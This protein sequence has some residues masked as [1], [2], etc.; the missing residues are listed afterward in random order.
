MPMFTDI[1]LNEKTGR[2]ELHYVN[3]QYDFLMAIYY[4]E[5]AKVYTFTHSKEEANRIANQW[6]NDF[7]YDYWLTEAEQRLTKAGLKLHWN[8]SIA[9]LQ[10]T[11]DVNASVKAAKTISE[12]A[13]ENDVKQL[14][15][16]LQ[17]KNFFIREAV[18]IPLARL[19]GA[20]ALSALFHA[21][22]QGEL[23]DHDN[24]GL[25][26]TIIGLLESNQKAVVP[27]LLNM[28]KSSNA[29][30]RIDAIWALGFVSSGV[31]PAVFFDRFIKDPDP[32]VRSVAGDSLQI[33]AGKKS[34]NKL[35][36][37]P[38][39]GKWMWMDCEENLKYGFYIEGIK[40]IC[41]KN[42]APTYAIGDVMLKISL[43]S[44]LAFVG[45]QIFTN[46]CWYPVTARREGQTLHM[47]GGGHTWA[48]SR[49][50]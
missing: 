45:E 46:G 2:H 35:D 47:Q 25:T 12:I 32:D 41:T 23:D 4:D 13:D 43:S 3:Q 18:A 28:L 33:Y 7:N 42:N 20:R 27:I 19:E 21:T 34:K 14:Y 6:T 49:V 48:M 10:N 26:N 16:L 50:E 30:T 15:E 17:N 9:A 24:D 38:F 1:V 39:V 11:D 29:D 8:D 44:G 36:I 37:K 22:K 40:G 31:E 5:V